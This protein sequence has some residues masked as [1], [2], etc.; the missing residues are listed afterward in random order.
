METNEA[1]ADR[2]EIVRAIRI[3][4]EPNQVVEV[5]VPSK[6]GAVSGYFDDRKKLTK[7][8]KR[9]S[10]KGD[11]AAVYIT[12]NP[13]HNGVLAR[14][15]ENSLHEVVKETTS[16]ADIVRRRWLLIDFDPKRPGGVSA[17]T[18]EKQ[19]AREAMLVVRRW[20]HRQGWAQPVV[21]DSG[22]GFH[23]LYRV[24]EP[25]DEDT[26]QSRNIASIPA[27]FQ[28]YKHSHCGHSGDG[29]ARLA[30]HHSLGCP[31]HLEPTRFSGSAV[32]NGQI[33]SANSR[34]ATLLPQ[35]IKSRCSWDCVM[36][37]KKLCSFVARFGE[38]LTG[39]FVAIYRAFTSGVLEVL[40]EQAGICPSDAL[41]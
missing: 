22:N 1:G 24:D 32:T 4:F 26:K 29:D 13:C 30:R 25:N 17:T 12:L 37:R 19:A 18:P 6:F 28:Q 3:L 39:I 2:N 34:S 36:T 15:S 9:L 5:R 41:A 11:Q 27:E 21:A 33:R 31:Y 8:I 40:L 10:D 23:L 35:M 16:D 20:L 14:R 38:V 7:A